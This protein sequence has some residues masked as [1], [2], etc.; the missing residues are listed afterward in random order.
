MIVTKKRS[1]YGTEKRNTASRK[2]MWS[3]A[4]RGEGNALQEGRIERIM[5]WIVVV[6]RGEENVLHVGVMQGRKK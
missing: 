6:W 5:K 3:A 4:R 2:K 1:C